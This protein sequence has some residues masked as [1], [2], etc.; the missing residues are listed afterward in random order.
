MAKSKNKKFSLE[1]KNIRGL[2]WILILFIGMCW[3]FVLGLVIGR[4]YKV[5]NIIKKQ[6]TIEDNEKKQ[7][8]NIIPPEKLVFLDKL[9]EIKNN[10]NQEKKENKKSKKEKTKNKPKKL[11]KSINKKKQIKEKFLYKYIYQ[12]ASYKNKSEAFFYLK[13]VKKNILK[14]CPVKCTVKMETTK[15]KNNIWHRI[16]ITIK[17]N[18]ESDA[19]LI[20]KQSNIKNYFL[21]GKKELK[22]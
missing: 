8:D 10:L 4:G 9:Q 5:Q 17:S 6:I 21:K 11:S 13:Q 16:L 20:L 14:V 15:I 12:C 1:T 22:R 3:A 7:Q 19:R 18:N 2:Y